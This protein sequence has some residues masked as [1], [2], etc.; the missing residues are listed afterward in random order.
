MQQIW[1]VSCVKAHTYFAAVCG[2]S[3]MMP[4]VDLTDRATEKKP[5]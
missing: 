4:D 5:V 3:H 2:L 1:A